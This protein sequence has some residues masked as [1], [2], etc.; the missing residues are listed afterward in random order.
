M[1]MI[2]DSWLSCMWV[3]LHLTSIINLNLRRY[4]VRQVY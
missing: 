4:F 2:L 3:W 1:N